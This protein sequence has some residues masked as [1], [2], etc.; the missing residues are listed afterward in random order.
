MAETIATYTVPEHH[1]KM[2][3]ANLRNVITKGGGL[4]YPY[5]DQG[6][7]VGDKIQVV[8]FIGPVEFIERTTKF[9]DTK[10]VELEHTS[11]W[12][13]GS[14]YDVAVLVD[15]LDTLKMIYEPTSPYVERMRQAHERKR[16]EI[17]VSKFFATALTGKEAS[18][19]TAYK[20]ANTVVDGGTGFTVAKLRSLR[21]LIK[22]RNVDLRT[23]KPMILINADC[24]DKLLGDTQVTSSD[25]AAV[26]ALVSGEVNEFMGFMFINYE[27]NKGDAT[28]GRGIPL[29]GNV[30]T[31]PVWMRD[32]MQ[33]GSWQELVVVISPR[34]DK[35]NIKQ[36]HATFTAGATRLDEDLVFGL[37]WDQTA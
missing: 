2:F 21:K 26:K 17:I 15:R 31:S 10:T 11:R 25:Y 18:T 30:R 33:Y 14:E 29:S 20:T 23:T 1:V 13:S 24:T 7:Y 37:A 9:A 4:V 6:S 28:S 19:S 36:L 3:T 12:I 35:N 8:N 34:P 5:V 27:D 32:G 16:D 22:K